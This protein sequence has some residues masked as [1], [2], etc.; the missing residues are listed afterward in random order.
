VI[1]RVN[2]KEPPDQGGWNVFV[3]AFAA[4]DMINPAT[5]RSLRAGGITGSPPGWPDDPQLENLRAEWFQA[6][7][8]DKRRELAG[9]IQERAF[10]FVT[11][12]PTGQ[13]RGRSAYRT[14][15]A[16]RLDAPIAF[17]WNIE[18]RQ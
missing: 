8:D 16:G 2:T 13:Y 1:R 18:K 11:Y 7:D 17:L 4:F 10:E 9:K 3:T 5:N 12:I 15:L 6:A 14:Y